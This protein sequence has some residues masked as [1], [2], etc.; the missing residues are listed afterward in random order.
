MDQA[1]IS[2]TQLA[3]ICNVSVQAVGGWKKTGRVNKKHL[4][5]IANLTGVPVEWLM[6]GNAAPPDIASDNLGV[7]HETIHRVPLI[8]WVK[9]G[10]YSESPD[11]FAPGDAEDWLPCPASCGPRTFALR[12]NGPSMAP[13]YEDGEVIFVDPEENWGH[14]SDVVI[15]TPDGKHTFKRLTVDSDGQYMLQALN[16][17]WPDRFLRMPPESVVCGVV[18]GSYRDRRR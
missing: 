15:R 2:N 9:A 4:P 10:Q 14:G 12:V 17:E 3:N 16:P 11:T 7:S 1:G 5:T 8:S 18:V 6:G 13:A